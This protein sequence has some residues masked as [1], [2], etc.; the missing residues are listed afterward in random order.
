[1]GSVGSGK[2]ALT[3]EL[4]ARLGVP[5][6]ETDHLVWRRSPGGPDVRNDVKTRDALLDAAIGANG[7]IAEGAHDKRTRRSFEEADL[8]V[9]LDTPVWRRNVRVLKRFA[10]QK[11]GLEHGNY[12]QTLAMLVNMYR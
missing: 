7:W 5:Y 4:S 1:M 10:R 11:P 9:Y 3:R 6:C 2:S 8:I 12:K